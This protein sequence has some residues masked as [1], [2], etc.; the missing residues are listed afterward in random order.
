MEDFKEENTSGI[1]SRWTIYVPSQ[2]DKELYT[3]SK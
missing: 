2:I 3:R 1:A